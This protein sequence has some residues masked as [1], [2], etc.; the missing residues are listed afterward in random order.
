MPSSG[1]SLQSAL[2]S[3]LT[4]DTQLASALGGRKVYDAPPPG[5]AMP[6]VT[7]G[8]STERDWSTGSDEGR[9]H[10]VTLL[11]WS[12]ARGRSE[13]HDLMGHLRR[14]LHDGALTLDG[15]RLVALRHELSE[16]RRDNDGETWRGLVRL[17]AVT[18]PA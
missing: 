14:V 8:Q 1:T 11:V 3:A 9:E 4:S 15:W 13:T 2:V 17:R 12:R 16:V 6:Y 7:L 10:T 18:E 5:A